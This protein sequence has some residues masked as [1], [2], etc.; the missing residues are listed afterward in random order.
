MATS[1]TVRKRQQLDRDKKCGITTFGIRAFNE[2]KV[3][4]KAYAKKLF[5]QRAANKASGA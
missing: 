1:S 4:I 5:D 3:A 2:D